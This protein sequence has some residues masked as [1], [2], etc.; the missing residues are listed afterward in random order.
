MLSILARQIA[1]VTAPRRWMS[2]RLWA[3]VVGLLVAAQLGLVLHQAS[4]HLRPD[5]VATDDCALCQATAGMTTGPAAPLLV[6]PVFILL[7]IV[8]QAPATG[9]VRARVASAFR[10]RAPPVRF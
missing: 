1:A 6:L 2:P 9:P 7:A 10:S 8:S 5:A 3:L 4:H